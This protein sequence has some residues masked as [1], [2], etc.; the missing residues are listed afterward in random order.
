MI[1]HFLFTDNVIYA[2]SEYLVGTTETR[3]LNAENSRTVKLEQTYLINFDIFL[4]W[5]IGV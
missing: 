2:D 3:P 1:I 4:G 5:L